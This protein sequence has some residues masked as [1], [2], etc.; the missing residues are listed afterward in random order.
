MRIP[1]PKI[2]SQAT[3]EPTL[4]FISPPSMT[5]EARVQFFGEAPFDDIEYHW[6]ADPPGCVVWTDER[7]AFKR[8]F[9][10]VGNGWVFC[11]LTDSNGFYYDVPPVGVRVTSPV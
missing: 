7:F 9:K 6:V 4:G 11:R 10:I 3:G 1:D 5:H 2:V 8:A